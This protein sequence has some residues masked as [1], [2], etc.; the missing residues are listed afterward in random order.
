[1]PHKDPEAR[2]AYGREWMRKNV[3]KARQAMR[4]WR[5]RHPEQHSAE[6]R[7]F[8]AR[9]RDVLIPKMVEYQRTHPEI[10][11]AKRQRRRARALG[12]E[13]AYTA[14]EW[15]ELLE[16]YEGRCA[17]CGTEA[18]LEADHRVPLARGG[19]NV[20]ANIL[21]ACAPC[22]RRKS[23]LAEPEFRARMAAGPAI[24]GDLREDGSET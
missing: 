22:N 2:R 10:A 3:E 11:H 1:M 16:R 13:G 6:A 5:Q 24:F 19:T 17:Y 23:T 8:Y 7:A 15:R 4:R 20:I 9:H 12:A 18:P 21:P 14:A